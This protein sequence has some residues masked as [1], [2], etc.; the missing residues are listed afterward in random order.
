MICILAAARFAASPYGAQAALVAPGHFR[1]ALARSSVRSSTLR[2][3]W[4]RMTSLPPAW[5][6]PQELPL[7]IRARLSALAPQAAWQLLAFLRAQQE[8]PVA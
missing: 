3:S 7:Q 6:E 1:A 2:Q 4:V 8:P 5:R